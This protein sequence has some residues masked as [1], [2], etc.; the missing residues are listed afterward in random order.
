MR[1]RRPNRLKA[2]WSRTL[3]PAVNYQGPPDTGTVVAHRHKRY[4]LNRVEPYVRQTDGGAS[5]LLHWSDE[6]GDGFTSGLRTRL[7]PNP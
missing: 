1:P 3:Y 4:T 6:K 5:F 7:S 2:D